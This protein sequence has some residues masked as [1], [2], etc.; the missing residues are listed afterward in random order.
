MPNASSMLT[1][2]SRPSASMRGQRDF[3]I[4]DFQPWAIGPRSNDF[5][6]LLRRRPL[7]LQLRLPVH[8]RRE[9]LGGAQVGRADVAV[10]ARLGERDA[11]VALRVG[12]R[13]H[14]RPR[15]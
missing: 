3:S 6:I 15:A 1:T 12:A 13:A 7:R 11:E 14:A 5:G 8:H 9:R 10:E 4:R 2:I